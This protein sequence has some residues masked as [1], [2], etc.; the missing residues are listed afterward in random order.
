VGVDA[1][2]DGFPADLLAYAA[3]QFRPYGPSPIYWITRSARLSTSGDIVMPMS[4]AVL[5]FTISS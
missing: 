5:R 4:R 3:L 2:G 1:G